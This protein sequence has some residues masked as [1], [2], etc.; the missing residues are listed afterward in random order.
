MARNNYLHAVLA[1]ALT[2][3]FAGGC[4]C[5]PGEAS[6][7]ITSPMNRASLTV[8]DDTM[9]GVDG[10]QI[11]V[12]AT[13]VSLEPGRSVDLYLDSVAVATA[14]ADTVGGLEWAGVTIPSGT[15]TLYAQTTSGGVRSAEVVVTSADACFSVSFIEPTVVG[16]SVRLGP[17]DDT[18]GEPCGMSF[19]TSF[20]IA[21]AAPD[22]SQ[23][24]L[25]VNGTPRATVTVSGGAARFDNIA[26]GN[27][28]MDSNVVR[29]VVTDAAGLGCG[30]DFP[31]PVFVQCDGPSCVLTEPASD[32]GFL[33]SSDDTSSAEGFQTDFRV[34]SDSG[35]TARL[36]LDGDETGAASA[37]FSG[38]TATF[39]NVGLSEGTH[40]AFAICTDDL[41]NTTRSGTGEWV[42]DITGC[43][44]GV[45]N[46]TE[47][48]AF[49]E[50]DDT[51]SATAGV[52]I[53][54]DGTA[55]ADCTGLRV[56][57]C[58]SIDSAMFG[59]VTEAWSSAVTLSTTAM[60]ELCFQ[61]RDEAGNISE[62]RI[63]VRFDSDAPQL[64]IESPTADTHFSQ[65][66]DLSGGDAVCDQAF[67][68]VCDAPG[69]T[70]EI[71]QLGT[72][73]LLGSAECVADVSAPMPYTGRA[74]FASVALPNLEDGT[75]YAVEARATAGRLVGRSAGVSIF[76]DCHAPELTVVRP[77]CGETLNPGTQD[78]DLG[79]A[80]FQYRTT[81]RNPTHPE[82]DVTLTIRPAGGG[83]PIFT[84]T[85]TGTTDV[86][87]VVADYGAGGM[88]ALEA[89]ATDNAGNTGTSPTC[90]V[91]VEDLPT[92][93]ITSPMMDDVIGA[94]DDC[95]GSAA[96]MQV[97]LTGTTD[98]PAG[99]TIS[100]EADAG[101]MSRTTAG[102][103]GAGG[104]ISVCADSPEGTV[105]LTVT[106]TDTRGSGSATVQVTVDSMPPTD[107][108]MP[109]TATVVDRRMG[110]VRFDWTAV[111]DAGGGNLAS[112]DLRCSASPITSEAEWM[113]ARV[114]PMSTVPGTAGTMQSEEV[115]GFRVGEHLNC[116]LRASDIT[117]ALTPI[118]D[119]V[120]V[121]LDFISTTVE[122]PGTAGLG[123]QIAA[124]G[125]INGDGVADILTG[126]TQSA[127]L[128]FGS[129]TALGT[130]PDVAF[131]S[132]TTNSFGR[133]VIGIGDLNGDGRMDFAVGAPFA[134]A[135]FPG[136]VA[137]FFGRAATNPWP[138]TCDVDGAC[139]PDLL[140]DPPAGVSRGL[141]FDLSSTD[142]D[143]DGTVDL[144][145]GAPAANSLAGEVYV[146]FGGTGL[147]SGSVLRLSPVPASPPDGSVIPDGWIIPAPTG[148]TQF[149]NGLA[150]LAGSADSD[151]LEDFVVA[152]PDPIS[153]GTS[154]LYLVHGRARAGSGLRTLTGRVDTIATAGRSRF[155]TLTAAGDL[156]GDGNL[157]VLTHSPAGGSAG[158][159]EAYF[160]DGTGFSPSAVIFTNDSGSSGGDNF[161]QVAGRG[162]Q[163]GIG[164]IGFL[165]ADL[166]TEALFGSDEIGAGAGNGYLFYGVASFPATTPLSE[167]NATLP[168]M[169]GKLRVGYVGDV[170]GDGH[171]DIALGE[172][173]AMGGVGRLTVLH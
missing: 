78:E 145:L 27:R 69:S 10:L 116:V 97:M 25:M 24:Q 32:T 34:T 141:G 41:G 95:D 29:V 164:N 165:N 144:I 98:A 173:D 42:I 75:S 169:E 45:D 49:I 142:F 112:Y 82:A 161:A 127:Y 66:T 33:N 89:T 123:T 163:P 150:G 55:G 74:T 73:T 6:L 13:S 106:V 21:T 19:E 158:Q 134:G 37:M 87:N 63:N 67:D 167:A 47:G 28:G 171:N 149:G 111:A 39:G 52:Q 40:R 11:T 124:V 18:D 83:A 61:T 7:E 110:I 4:S 119:N 56:G 26:L 172:P 88:L 100:V 35:V 9:P 50:T 76:S 93:V 128:W 16:G 120:A 101:A 91:N 147:T 138:A 152:A 122:R 166:R 153:A 157:D 60:Q 168:G 20:I 146:I 36:V 80:G 114:F 140:I 30:A 86:V 85:A 17:S 155:T 136:R 65:A 143:G 90:V 12:T 160:G 54:A 135:G 115:P 70:V 133:V 103:V 46:P 130:T 72:E 2:G 77:T 105:R 1:L 22:G 64:R 59:A 132:T 62:Q 81:I 104:A 154:H 151:A 125:D 139:A 129:R 84:S 102:T 121:N 15:H 38:T 23:A 137:V 108:I 71:Y 3:G 131:T 162:R 48:Q 5:D 109:V 148:A 107:A 44:I 53:G 94:G 8:A 96:G 92:V 170:D 118:G 31:A 113:D 156:N 159:G 68:V 79:R 58:G 99:S 43:G 117:G 51:D 14:T 126:G 57:Q